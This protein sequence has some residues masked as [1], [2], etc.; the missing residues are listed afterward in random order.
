M[1]L[2]SVIKDGSFRR[3]ARTLAIPWYSRY[4][5]SARVGPKDLR[6]PRGTWGQGDFCAAELRGPRDSSER[7]ELSEKLAGTRIT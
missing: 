6:D 7:T 4:H 5:C 1:F 3:L 2:L